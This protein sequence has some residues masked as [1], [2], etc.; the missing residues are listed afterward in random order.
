LEWLQKQRDPLEFSRFCLEW[1]QMQ[2]DP[3]EFSRFCL[4]WLQMQRDLLEFSRFG[5]EWLQMKQDPLEFSRFGLEWLQKQRNLPHVQR[6]EVLK[7]TAILRNKEQC[8][9]RTHGEQHILKN[10]DIEIFCHSSQSQ[11]VKRESE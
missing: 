4:E 11:T 2:R 6:V 1:L 10:K 5:L 3:L 7:G 8:S 9:K